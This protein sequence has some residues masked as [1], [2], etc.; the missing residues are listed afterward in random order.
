VCSYR[1]R[2]EALL[3]KEEFN[4]TVDWL[5]PSIDAVIISAQGSDVNLIFA[6]FCFTNLPYTLYLSTTLCSLILLHCMVQTVK[7]IVLCA[8]LRNC[9]A[10]QDI[11]CTVLL[12]GN[13]LN[14][15][16]RLVYH[17]VPVS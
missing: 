2:I 8:D 10:I 9:R 14:T 17:Y 1:L 3:L 15:V 16:S 7:Y 12:V 5:K 4:Q 11:L 6:L 13:F